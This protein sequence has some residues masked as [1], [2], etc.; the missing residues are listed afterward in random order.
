M[1]VS[2]A[3]TK[4]PQKSKQRASIELGISHGSLSRLMQRLGLKMY[5]PRLLLG[6]LEDDPDRRLQF[7]E[8][9]QNEERQSNGIIDKITWSDEAHFK[10]PGAVN[11]HNCV[12][13]STEN[14][15]VTEEGQL[16]QPG[17]IFW[18]GLSCKG[19]LGL[20]FLHT[21]VTHGLYLNMPR[22]IVLPQL[23]R[24][25]DND[26]FFFQQDGAPLHYAVT[27]RNFLDE[28]N[29]TVMRT[30]ISSNTTL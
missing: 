15:H 25:H 28:P 11:Q 20:I 24:Q 3:F 7:C 8:V 12:S 1:L 18:A 29:Q 19:I 22:N 23:Q 30:Y 13:H 9:I 10:L 21:A 4:S 17:V 2:Q 27:V 26:D 14:P 5:R 16:N 6:L